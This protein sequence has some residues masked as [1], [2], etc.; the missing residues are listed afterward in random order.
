MNPLLFWF[1]LNWHTD[2]LYHCLVTIRAWYSKLL[3]IL[4][5]PGALC[6]PVLTLAAWPHAGTFT[7]PVSQL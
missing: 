7:S 1:V 5:E 4:H 3:C 6:S 2:C